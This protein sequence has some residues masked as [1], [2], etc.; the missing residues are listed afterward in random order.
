MSLVSE[1]IEFKTF[2]KG[3]LIVPQSLSAPTSEGFQELLES[4]Q[5]LHETKETLKKQQ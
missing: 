3:E 5:K 1:L 2:K 4:H